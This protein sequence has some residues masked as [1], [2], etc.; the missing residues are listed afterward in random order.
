MLCLWGLVGAGIFLKGRAL[1][2]F[3]SDQVGHFLGLS[4]RECL[5][6]G[7][8]RTS[9]DDV[10]GAL[11]CSWGTN[12]FACSLRR[13]HENMKKL[14]WVKDVVIIRRL[15]STLLVCIKEKKP[16]AVWQNNGKKVLISDEGD[17]I[18]GVPVSDDYLVVTGKDAPMHTWRLLKSLEDYKEKLPK[19]CAATFLRSQRWDI[20]LEDK[21]CV[22]LSEKNI[23]ESLRRLVR[24]LQWQREKKRTITTIDL[25]FIDAV[26][27]D[28]P[29]TMAKKP[30]ISAQK[31]S[32]SVTVP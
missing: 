27:M 7:R 21:T 23:D 14:P 18:A 8:V 29:D 11:G 1:L 22:K 5:I 13:V 16:M 31:K 20:Y 19:V 2:S 12:I 25:R 9:T 17:V 30:D 4:L 3:V 15:P 32:S 10:W 6:E 28:M 24:V 26:I